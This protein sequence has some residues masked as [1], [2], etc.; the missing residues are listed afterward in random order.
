[1]FPKPLQQSEKIKNKLAAQNRN[2]CKFSGGKIK[3]NLII[4][5]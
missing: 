4:I 2:L 5:V 3:K 1:M